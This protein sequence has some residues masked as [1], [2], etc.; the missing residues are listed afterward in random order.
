[1]LIRIFFET[2]QLNLIH[3]YFTCILINKKLI[4]I[5]D[6]L[7]SLASFSGLRNS[8]ISADLELSQVS[9]CKE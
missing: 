1:M 6:T 2:T 7:S 8:G 3:I 9:E 5:L 4:R